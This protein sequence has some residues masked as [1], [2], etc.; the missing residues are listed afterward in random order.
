MFTD[1]QVKALREIADREIGGKGT[2]TG[3]AVRL[4][5]AEGDF[6]NAATREQVVD[7]PSAEGGRTHI[8]LLDSWGWASDYS[9]SAGDV[10]PVIHVDSGGDPWFDWVGVEFFAVTDESSEHFRD[11]PARWA[12]PGEIAKGKGREWWGEEP[13]ETREE[14]P[15][16][17]QGPLNALRDRIHAMAADKGWWDEPRSPGEII[18]LC[19]SELSEALEEVRNG[20]P[21]TEV[22]KNPGKPGKPGKPE[23]VPVELADCLIRILDYFGWLGVDVDEVVNRKL[24]Y[25]ATRPKRHG[26]KVL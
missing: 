6:L 14:K 3:D 10:L 17:E 13:A 5:E 25:N 21:P 4:L 11:W 9:P 26:G 2:M 23:G 20:H 22:Y 16:A 1:E 18:A 24:A 12:T 15:D 8:V 19:H 7:E